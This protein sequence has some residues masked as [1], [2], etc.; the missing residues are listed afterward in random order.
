MTQDI[1]IDINEDVKLPICIKMME[2]LSVLLT[3]PEDQSEIDFFS[4]ASYSVQIAC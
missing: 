1:N 3:W 2:E 4:E